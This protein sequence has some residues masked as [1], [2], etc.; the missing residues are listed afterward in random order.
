MVIHYCYSFIVG[1]Y[2]WLDRSIKSFSGKNNWWCKKSTFHLGYTYQYDEPTRY[3]SKDGE[4]EDCVLYWRGITKTQVVCLDDQL[5][6]RLYPFVCEK[7]R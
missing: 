3:E 5:C 1:T 7:C 6:S 2:R 4:R